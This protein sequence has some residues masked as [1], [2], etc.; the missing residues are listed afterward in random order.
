MI[1]DIIYQKTALDNMEIFQS[2]FQQNET[3]LEFIYGLTFFVLGV[4]ISLQSRYSSRLELARSLRWLAAFG[5]SHG[6]YVW[7]KSFIPIQATYLYPS[8]AHGVHFLHLLLLIL[9]YVCLFEFGIAL[10]RPFRISKTLNWILAGWHTLF[11]LLMVS[12]SLSTPFD[13]KTFHD[14]IEALAGYMIAFPS[15]LFAAYGLR[16]QTYRLIA[17]LEAPY[18]VSMLRTAGISLAVFGVLRGFV[19]P[20]V[21]FFPGNWLNLLTFENTLGI[22]VLVFLVLAG[23]VLLFSMVRALEVFHVEMER[24]IEHMEQQQILLAERERIARE[25]HDNTLQMAYT[26]GLLIDSARKLADPDSA[27]A[28]RLDRAVQALNEV[29]AELRR[30]MNTLHSPLTGEAP[31]QAIRQ[32]TD[33]PRFRT[34]VDI[35][36]EDALPENWTLPPRHSGHLLAILQEALSNVVRH[37]G[38][39]RVTLHLHQDEKGNTLLILEDDGTGLPAQIREGY[40]LRN[41]RERARMMGGTLTLSN[42]SPE[43]GTRL[44]LVIPPERTSPPEWTRE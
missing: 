44:A 35:H 16:E 23:G 26:A 8:L 11:T 1:F 5:F 24:T 7:G 34:L 10:L 25:L 20:P 6:L 41:M 9:S 27:I 31:R 42:R 30:N 3:F 15:G 14:H 19:P 38:A 29:I 4:A 17:P 13:L 21:Q 36:L 37:S 12:V 43:K 22:P 33:D 39:S 40:G 32:L 28:L 2:F 18:V